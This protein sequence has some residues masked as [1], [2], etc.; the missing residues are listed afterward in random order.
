MGSLNV[1]A[2]NGW[3]NNPHGFTVTDGRV[4][5]PRPWDALFN[6]NLGHEL[7]HMYIA[8]YMV[9][10]FI[11]AG[12]YAYARLQGKRDAYHRTGLVV[13][14]SFA[15]L[16]TL[17]QG[18]VGDWA[19]R[20]VAANQP[21]KLAAFEGLPHTESE[22]PFTIGGF[23]DDDEQEVRYGIQI[24]FLLSLLS[25]HDP[26]AT[27][28]GLDSVPEA[29]R[30]PVNVVRFAFQA[31]VGIGTVL[32]LLSLVYLVTWWRRRRLPR[33]VWFLRAVVVAGPLALVALIGGWVATEVGR[34]PWI[35]YETMRTSDAVT[36]SDGLEVA[37]GV[38]VAV[39]LGLTVALVWLLRRLTSRPEREL[40]EP[41]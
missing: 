33:S 6:D 17:C 39:Y 18:A 11:V 1:I 36:A 7:V 38:L 10:G 37:F 2:V 41:G 26:Q 34:Q 29:D 4:T 13:A 28:T 14:L 22:A 9:A 23:Y 8:G 5:D 27:V 21:V 15:A 31:M 16:A 19:G 12:V 20:H 40:A 32:G 30:P 35:V 25:Q 24:P 3:M